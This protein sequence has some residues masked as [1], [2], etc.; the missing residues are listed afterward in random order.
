MAG[1]DKQFLTSRYAKSLKK[2]RF[3]NIKFSWDKSF[4]A[5]KDLVDQTIDMLYGAGFRKKELQVFMLCNW[6]VSYEECVKKLKF[7]WE[8]GVQ[9]ADCWFQEGSYWSHGDIRI[10]KHI[11]RRHNILVRQ[12]CKDI[13]DYL[14]H[15]GD[16]GK[17]YSLDL[18]FKRLIQNSDIDKIYIP[19]NRNL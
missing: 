18:E 10:F 8:K 12:D 14:S 3:K 9:I 15:G 1:I 16:E 13:D 5:E 17:R 6:K 7:L 2:N 11:R 4:D 19:E